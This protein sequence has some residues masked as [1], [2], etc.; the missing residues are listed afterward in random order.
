MSV[1]KQYFPYTSLLLTLVFVLN[2][3]KALQFSD[4]EN[5]V[6]EVIQKYFRHENNLFV[7]LTESDEETFLPLFH[8]PVIVFTQD[9]V[10]LQDCG[11]NVTDQV[12]TS[13]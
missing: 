10:L 13:L 9:Q 1:K 2:C 12:G 8:V 5:K 3:T 6:E 7:V 4:D 11:R